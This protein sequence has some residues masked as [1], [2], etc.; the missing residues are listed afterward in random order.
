MGSHPVKLLPEG[1]ER[2]ISTLFIYLCWENYRN[3][4]A[5][6]KSLSVTGSSNVFAAGSV[7][8]EKT[9]TEHFVCLQITHPSALTTILLSPEFS[10]HFLPT[11]CIKT[12]KSGN[13]SEQFGRSE[14]ECLPRR[15]FSELFLTSVAAWILNWVNS[16]A[17]KWMQWSICTGSWNIG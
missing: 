11:V 9:C 14:D 17:S 4:H 3:T 10:I 7:L 12:Q 6:A 13:H 16:E 1:S 8:Q 15:R 5:A 2:P